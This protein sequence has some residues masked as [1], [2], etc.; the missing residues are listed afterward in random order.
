MTLDVGRNRDDFQAVRGSENGGNILGRG[1]RHISRHD[2]RA[3]RALSSGG[4]QP[5]ADGG[6]EIETIGFRQR[7]GPARARCGG[8]LGIPC[9]NQRARNARHPREHAQHVAQHGEH[10]ALPIGWRERRREALLGLGEAFHRH[11]GERRGFAPWRAG[12]E[13]FSS[14]VVR[15]PA[16]RRQSSTDARATLIRSSSV[17]MIVSAVK[18]GKSNSSANCESAVSSRKPSIRPP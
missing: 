1:E 3:G 16:S 18:T 12:H 8:N 4:Q 13:R 7:D 5:E 9:D 17:R 11:D 10:Q 6:V 15:A 14:V 2:Q